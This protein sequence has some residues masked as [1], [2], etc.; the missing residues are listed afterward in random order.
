[1]AIEQTRAPFH[2]RVGFVYPSQEPYVK[3][4][5][6][7]LSKLEGRIAEPLELPALAGPNDAIQLIADAV[8][9]VNFVK[10]V[11]GAYGVMAAGALGKLG[12]AI[13]DRV[14]K[15][16]AKPRPDDQADVAKVVTQIQ[17]ALEDGLTVTLALPIV[18]NRRNI[19]VQIKTKDPDEIVRRIVQ[20]GAQAPEIEAELVK[21]LTA[22]PPALPRLG[23]GGRNDDCSDKVTL[24]AD[25]RASV[26]LELPF[27]PKG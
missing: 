18:T 12:Q 13:A 2:L 11:V 6:S 20:F 15:D 19:G 17:R 10:V 5:G 25:G 14:L 9:W 3:E 16:P 7:A 26:Q 1:M 21:G 27:T 4:I 24:D 8:S 23:E 22:S